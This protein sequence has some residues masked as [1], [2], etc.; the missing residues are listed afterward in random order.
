MG[1]PVE[2]YNH[3]GIEVKETREIMASV[4]IWLESL[5]KLFFEYQTGD[6]ILVL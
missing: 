1:A 5:E 6:F 4:E 3:L 2:I